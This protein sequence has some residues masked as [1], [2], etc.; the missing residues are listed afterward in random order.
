MGTR[1]NGYSF[2]IEGGRYGGR[3]VSLTLRLTGARLQKLGVRLEL[4]IFFMILR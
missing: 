1:S 4:P 2:L 3:F